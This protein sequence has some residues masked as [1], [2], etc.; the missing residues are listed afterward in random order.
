[1]ASKDV[2]LRRSSGVIR[3]MSPRDAA[4]YGYLVI[5]G[6]YGVT[7]YFM[8]GP[9]IFPGAN[10]YLA[11][12]ILLG[13]F[14]V[15]WVTYSGLISA[16]PR[17]GGD[18][19]FS[20]RLVSGLVGF[21]ATNAGMVWWQV[22]WDY[23][24]GNTI[25]LVIIPQMLDFVGHSTNNPSLV[26]TG[27]A[28]ANPWV[29][30]AISIILLWIALGV[31]LTGLRAYVV[32]QNF[33]IMVFGAIALVLVAGMFLT[34]PQSTFITNFNSYQ[35][36][37]G[38]NPDWYHTIITKAKDL[39]FNPDAGFSW[40]DTIGLAALYYGLWTAV[41]FGM[42]LVGEIK[43]VQSFKTAWVTQYGA[44]LLEFVTFAV[45]IA[46]A[47]D[48][49]GPEFI[50]SL[51][52]L[53][54]FAPGAV[55]GFDFRGSYALFTVVTLN[56]PIGIIIGLAFAGAMANS[57]FNGFLG[58][59]RIVLAQSF[60]RIYPGWFGHVN[61][62]G[63]PDN[64]FIDSGHNPDQLPELSSSTTTRTDGPIHRIRDV[65]LRRHSLPMES[66]STLRGVANKQV[67]SCWHTSNHNMRNS[68]L[69]HGLMGDLLL[70]YK[71]KLWHLARHTT[72]TNIRVTTLHHTLRI[73]PGNQ[74]I[75]QEPRNRHN[76]GVQRGSACLRLE[77]FSIFSSDEQCV[78]LNLF[79]Y[80]F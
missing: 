2:F 37:F 41:S 45:G 56:V 27:L 38:S 63:A 22:F 8:S 3:T 49:M 69:R 54:T 79:P 30:A 61:K 32:F 48:Y 10:I 7:F 19:V 64:I 65:N 14:A 43:G 20:S 28:L 55:P 25:A 68:R 73:L 15:R 6:F 9:A 34:V 46:W 70:P 24:A 13:L 11:M 18:Y 78:S 53:A 36:I 71:S 40:Y 33:F 12:L 62:R 5:A 21:V 23:L 29:G 52:Y 31:M 57:L 35:N 50:R 1:M 60:D 66:Q 72:S 59:S 58:A 67:Q 44:I 42:E 80:S 75:P 26:N 51:G 16:M 17:S 77:P 4:F 74:T 39:G 76:S 47:T